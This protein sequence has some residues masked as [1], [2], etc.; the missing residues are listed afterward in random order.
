MIRL[1]V[2]S[3]MGLAATLSSCRPTDLTTEELSA[4]VADPHN[5]LCKQHQTKDLA[6]SVSYQPSVLLGIP[7]STPALNT[8]HQQVAPKQSQYFLLTFSRNG[9]EALDP[10]RGFS[11]FSGLLQTLA[12]RPHEYLRI[13]TA[14]GDT[15]LP[16]NCELER[17]YGMGTSTRLLV[18]FP[19]DNL[20]QDITFHLAEFG[21][22]T[23]F[24]QFYFKKRDL[25][26]VP[27]LNVSGTKEFAGI[28]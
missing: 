28:L 20:T 11:A 9:Q 5:G 7:R 22:G 10:S 27:Q 1:L 14:T 19:L 4:Y 25:E 8:L 6:V 26:S 21:L 16:S 23:G 3:F 15:L 12:F 17:T 13:T 18:A 24:L 2:V